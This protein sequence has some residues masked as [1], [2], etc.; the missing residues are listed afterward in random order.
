ME[1]KSEVTNLGNL[2]L[3]YNIR[4][5]LVEVWKFVQG[6]LLGTAD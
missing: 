3:E 1:V 6:I 4:K 2:D 5:V